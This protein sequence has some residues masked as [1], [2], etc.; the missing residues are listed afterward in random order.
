MQRARAC[1]LLRRRCGGAGAG[2]GAGWASL[3]GC[4]AVQALP[5]VA[6]F[7]DCNHDLSN[8]MQEVRVMEDDEFKLI[9]SL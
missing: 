7:I 1:D 9:S 6:L 8:A 2:S 4:A 5:C 3:A